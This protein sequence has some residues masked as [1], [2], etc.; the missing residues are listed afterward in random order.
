MYNTSGCM[1]RAHEDNQQTMASA[2]HASM[3]L[4]SQVQYDQAWGLSQKVDDNI[5]KTKRLPKNTKQNV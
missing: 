2:M 5:E 3:A 4:M 1:E